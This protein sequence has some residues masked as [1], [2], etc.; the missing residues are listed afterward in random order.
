[1]KPTTTSLVTIVAE[2]DLEDGLIR[3]FREAG[4]TGYTQS[5]VSGRGASQLQ[6]DPSGDTENV[7]FKILL[8]TLMSTSLMRTIIREFSP[9]GKVIVFQQDAMVLRPEKF[10]LAARS[11]RDE[12]LRDGGE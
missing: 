5:H 10:G 4:I 1:M 9:R 2:R 7:Q 3:F 8:P 12:R 6:S 11:W